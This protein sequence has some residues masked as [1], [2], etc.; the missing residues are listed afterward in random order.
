[1]EWIGM[2]WRM[3]RVEKKQRTTHEIYADPY[4]MSAMTSKPCG[5]L[6]IVY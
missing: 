6:D 5:C 4:E 3:M 1:M 2:D